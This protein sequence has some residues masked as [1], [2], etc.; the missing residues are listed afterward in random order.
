[1]K[2]GGAPAF[3]MFS[4]FHFSS[5]PVN[6]WRKILSTKCADRCNGDRSCFPLR[7]HNGQE[8]LKGFSTNPQI[9]LFLLGFIFIFIPIELVTVPVREE[10]FFVK[11]KTGDAV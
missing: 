3:G 6:F 4:T 9:L 8:S 10:T 2:C 5:E 7:F 11:W 1:M